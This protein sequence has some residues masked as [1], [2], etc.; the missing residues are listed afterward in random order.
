MN[1]PKGPSIS[2]VLLASLS[3]DL[4]FFFGTGCNI[5]NVTSGGIES[6]ARPI[7]DCRGA[8]EEKD[9]EETG[10]AGSRNE[11]RDIEGV[12]AIA[13]SR[14]FDRAVESIVLLLRGFETT[15]NLG[16]ILRFALGW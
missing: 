3:A 14:P 4:A 6:A 1:I 9:R 5:L 12:E 8:E 7:Y 2:T 10:K 15:W 13:L 11:G 16:D